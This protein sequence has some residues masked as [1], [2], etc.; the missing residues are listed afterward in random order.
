MSVIKQRKAGVVIERS[1]VPVLDVVKAIG[2]GN[3]ISDLKELFPVNDKEIWESINFF[4]L[5]TNFDTKKEVFNVAKV[6]F[7]PKDNE[8]ELELLEIT[9]EI[10]LR[11]V[12]R[13]KLLNPKIKSISSAFT[14]GLQHVVMQMI[15]AYK[16]NRPIE[17]NLTEGNFNTSV[18]I[19]VAQ[20]ISNWCEFNDVNISNMCSEYENIDDYTNLKV[21]L[22]ELE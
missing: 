21:K 18:D 7:I 2:V 22:K 10:Y 6:V 12:N 5:N 3:E 9:G 14:N 15:R 4:C 1:A 11:C 16:L 19:H 17:N 13:G 20:K 8:V